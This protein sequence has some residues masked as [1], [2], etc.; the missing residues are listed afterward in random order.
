MDPKP[1]AK[2]DVPIWLQ[3]KSGGGASEQDKMNRSLNSDASYE[4][5]W[6]TWSQ[7]S[8]VKT[9]SQAQEKGFSGSGSVSKSGR[10]RGV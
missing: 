9:G 10:K 4:D 7:D 2:S 5:D 8:P 6:D 3:Q 1:E